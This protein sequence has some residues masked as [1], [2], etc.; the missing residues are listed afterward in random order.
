M[1]AS[2][3]VLAAETAIG[4]YPVESIDMINSI[5]CQYNRWS[6]ESSLKDFIS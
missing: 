1:G 3:L 5:I 2:G 6:P 4:D